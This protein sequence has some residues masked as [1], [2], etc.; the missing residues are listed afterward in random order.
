MNDPLYDF[1]DA[2]LY[3][4]TDDKPQ[5]VSSVVNPENIDSGL[6]TGFSEIVAGGLKQGKHKFDNT[7]SGFILGLDENLAKFYIGSTTSYLN[8]DGTT[9]TIFGSITATSGFFG[10]SPNGVSITSTGLQLSGTGSI[11]TGTSGVRTVISKAIT[12]G[13]DGISVYNVDDAQ[14]FYASG[15]GT[16]FAT[17]FNTSVS[18]IGTA[19]FAEN[20]VLNAQHLV[21][22]Q[23]DGSNTTARQAYSILYLNNDADHGDALQI[24]VDAANDGSGIK[25]IN[26]GT[27]KDILGTSST[28]SISKAGAAVF[29][30]VSG[31]GS[32]LTGISASNY[33]QFTADGTWT[34]PSGT[35]SGSLVY[36]QM[37]GG[38]GGGGGRA[39]NGGGTSGGGGGGGGAYIEGW[40][41][42]SALGSTVSVTVGTGGA[43]STVGAVGG[44]SVFSNL[45]AYG[46]GGGNGHNQDTGRAA[47]GGGGTTS[48]GSVGGATTG[49]AGG[50]LLGGA[51]GVGGSS[52]ADS[53]FGGG[54]GCGQAG[55]AITGGNSIYGGGGGGGGGE[56]TIDG[57]S[58]G[59][60][61]Y[62]G[63]GG[64]GGGQAG[65]AGGTS[66]V[67]GGTGGAGK[68]YNVDAVGFDGSIPGGGGGGNCGDAVTNRA[69]GAGG[70]GE[71][72]VFTFF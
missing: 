19:L 21:R 41:L 14:V 31:D 11:A 57:E 13:N 23:T 36:V 67:G 9:L 32:A 53:G 35:D 26:A 27:G 39:N 2:S 4:L 63:G 15:N 62:G 66:K 58:G 29:A 28:W 24:D 22:M 20:G 71:V 70:R 44:N 64:G 48:V 69:G 50:G 68:A 60:S 37:W 7:E 16:P 54:G 25:F 59:S 51:G 42:A 17:Q 3:K 18:T 52:G 33:Q 55:G 5:A 34:K 6:S 43:G 12:A 38:G 8:W 47:G 40:F 61:N 56:Q 10:T 46:G 1:V 65:G 30:S 49:G 72:R 45:T